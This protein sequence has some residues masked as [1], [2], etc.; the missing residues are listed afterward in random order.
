GG[1]GL[2]AEEVKLYQDSLTTSPRGE[3][4]PTVAF[5]SKFQAADLNL[6]CLI[7]DKVD[8]F[9]ELNGFVAMTRVFSGEV[10]LGQQLYVLRDATGEGQKQAE[11]DESDVAEGVTVTVSGIYAVLASSLVPTKQAKAGCIVGLVLQGSDEVVDPSSPDAFEAANRSA[12]SGVTLSSCRDMPPF[13]SPFEGQQS[14][15]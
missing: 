7:G 14:I 9:R 15:V 4:A 3:E 10:Q 8:A 5:V 11:E 6:G 1:G 13:V 2:S 12:C